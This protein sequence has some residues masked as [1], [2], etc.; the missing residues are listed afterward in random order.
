MSFGSLDGDLIQE[1]GLRGDGVDLFDDWLCNAC[2]IM[3]Y[4]NRD[5]A[6]D[7]GEMIIL[8][9]DR[10]QAT[11]FNSMIFPLA[12]DSERSTRCPLFARLAVPP[13]RRGR[14]DA[15]NKSP[16]Y[17][18]SH[19]LEQ[20]RPRLSVVVDRRVTWYFLPHRPPAFDYRSM[21]ATVA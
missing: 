11:G 16:G 20:S 12:T 6:S 21:V 13:L 4:K 1:V 9:A 19:R 14:R 17:C 18:A 7:R 2:E 3:Q 10:W 8:I 15:R 5:L